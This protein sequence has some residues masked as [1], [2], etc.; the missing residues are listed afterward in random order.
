MCVPMC[1]A[2]LCVFMCGDSLCVPVCG[3]SLCVFMCGA[4]LCVPMSGASLCVLMCGEHL[5][6][7]LFCFVCFHLSYL[8]WEGGGCS[9]TPMLVNSDGWDGDHSS[10]GGGWG[11]MRLLLL[12][13][14][15]VRLHKYC[16]F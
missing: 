8:V 2:S 1:G 10:P 13:I 14:V 15:R 11:V 4:S 5:L 16:V 7:C 3:A 9:F 6:A 12:L